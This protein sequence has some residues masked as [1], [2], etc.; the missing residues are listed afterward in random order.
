[1]QFVDAVLDSPGTGCAFLRGP[2]LSRLLLAA[3]IGF[4]VSAQGQVHAYQGSP[5][6]SARP[7]HVDAS[8]FV[9]PLALTS[10]PR[11]IIRDQTTFWT[12]PFRM[13]QSQWQWTVPLALLGTG[14]LASDTAIEQHVP[15]SKTTASHAV[16]VSNAGVAALVGV[17]AGMYL[18]GRSTHHDAPRETGLLAGEA[19]VDAFLDTEVLKYAFGRERPFTGDGRGHFFQSGTSFPSQHAAVGW[20][21]ASVIAHEYPGPLTQLLVYGA[22]SGISAARLIGQQHFATDVIVGSALGWYMGRQVFRAHSRYSAAEIAK[23]GTFTKGEPEDTSHEPRNM[24]SPFVPLD[25]WI[26]PA[27]ERLIADGYIHSAFL[28]MRPWTRM[29]CARL[30]LHEANETLQDVNENDLQADKLYEALSVEFSSELSRLGGDTNLGVSIDSVYSRLSGISGTLLHDGLHF[31][32][33]IVNDY[34]RP[35][36]EGLNNVTGIS[37][38]AVAGPLSFYVRAEYQHAPSI[39]ALSASAAQTIQNADGLPSAPPES[40]MAAVNHLE[41]LEGYVGM[42]LNHWQFSFGKQALWWGPDESG[43]TL[44]S[45]NAAPI[46]MF[47]INRVTPFKLPVLGSIRVDYVVGRLTGQHWVFGE[48]SGFVGSWLQTLGNQPF[49][50]GQKVSL[51]PTDNLEFSFSSTALFGGPG[52][53]ATSHKLLQAMF[54]TGNGVPGSSGDAGD[55]RGAFDISYRISKLNGLTLYADAFTDDAQTPWLAWNKAAL[56]SG[57]HL[58]RVPGIPK[59]DLRGEGLYSDPPSSNSTVRHGF[60]Y[61]NSRFK[62]GYTNDGYLIGSWIGRQGQGAQAWA[63]YWLSPRNNIQLNFRHQKVSPE[64]IPEGGTLTDIGVTADYWFKH[65]LGISASIKYERWLFPILQPGPSKNVAGS[66]SLIFEPTKLF[67]RSTA[68]N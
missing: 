57:F 2:F 46:L 17:G 5:S 21:V 13:T 47:R 33:T 12:T 48:N 55:R 24:G 40:P 19:A 45:T 63:T 18:W 64:F 35:Y 37:A 53:P 67:H 6:T 58:A 4:G 3:T 30:L 29:E 1:M 23:W 26:Y 32:Q 43:P 22:A 51:K 59:L 11:N 25:S 9:D 44:F 27:M 41:L 8:D 49:I 66:V 16:T 62:S 31:G 34:G 28:G 56:I 10:L 7:E 68:A 61:S 36:A 15:T 65:N 60:F 39:P 14:L 20:A 38:H 54:S 52:V 50:V 42:Q